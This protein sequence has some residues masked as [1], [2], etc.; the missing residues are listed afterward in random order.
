L[1][2]RKNPAP[3]EPTKSQ[4]SRCDRI[5]RR[6]VLISGT[7]RG[8]LVDSPSVPT[9]GP[10][11]CC[12]LAH[13]WC[14]PRC[15]A[16]A[17]AHGDC[18][19][20]GSGEGQDGQG[21]PYSTVLCVVG[22]VLSC[23][24]PFPSFPFLSFPPLTRHQ[25]DVSY[26]SPSPL[27]PCCTR[28]IPRGLAWRSGQSSRGIRATGE[29]RA[30][31]PKGGEDGDGDGQGDGEESHTEEVEEWDTIRYDTIPYDTFHLQTII[32]W[33]YYREGEGRD[34]TKERGKREDQRETRAM[35]L[36]AKAPTNR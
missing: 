36:S 27:F 8:D 15:T 4:P 1:K 7:P 35:V 2:R 5:D 19:G 28:G 3:A 13:A 6:G 25:T 9:R 10:W 30:E 21:A 20:S 22:N 23:N 12:P 29:A 18:T 32:R 26:V 33:Y 14:A 17:A 24:T 31:S 34:S 11:D 16:G